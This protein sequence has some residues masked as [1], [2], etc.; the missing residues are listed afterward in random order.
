MKVAEK[1]GGVLWPGLYLTLLLVGTCFSAGCAASGSVTNSGS[2]TQ[3]YTLSGTLTPAA[4]GGGASVGLSGPIAA[5][6][7]AN[8]SGNYSFTNLTNGTY[9][10]TPS[11]PGYT[12]SPT[13]QNVTINGENVTVPTFTATSA[14]TISGTISPATFGSGA[15]VTLSGAG[16]ATSTA[17][18][19]GDFSFTSLNNGTYTI[20]PASSTATFSPTSQNVTVS[21]ANVT[22]VNFIGNSSATQNACG[23]TLTSASPTCQVIGSGHL[24]PAWT[25]ISRHGEY[26]QNET[27]CNIPNAITTPPL[28]ITTSNASYDCG[29]FNE[30]GTVDDTP[31]SW[32]YTTGDIQWTYASFQY[33]T[34]TVRAKMPPLDSGTW[35]AHWFLDIR[36]QNQNIYNASASA[37]ADSDYTEIDMTECKTNSSGY[38]GR[39]CTT[40]VFH[41]TS[42]TGTC[43]WNQTPIDTNFH[44]Y[45]MTWASGSLS[46]TMDGVST[47][48]SFSGAS[49]PSGAVFMII[50]NQ[51]SLGIGPPNNSYLPT[52]M[53]TDFVSVVNSSGTLIF[54]DNFAPDIYFAQTPA[55]TGSG[56]DCADARAT[57]SML[58]MDWV[59]GNTL[60]LCGA[61]TSSITALGSGTSSNPITLTFEPGAY[62]TAPVWSSAINLNGFTFIIV[63]TIPCSGTGCPPS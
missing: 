58:A 11:N 35:P 8:G 10:V 57:S 29:D 49:V 60:H 4:G 12:F 52:T 43:S 42:P 18:S 50:Q 31:T 16:A 47:G 26:A 34:V 3:T 53:V 32:P 59:P 23:D 28:T 55:G 51:T 5:S 20:T 36:C 14:Y 54:Q 7:T 33:G 1:S 56:D 40:N 24:N 61:L 25:V 48:C 62:F 39:W 17:D 44:T 19:S 9:A 37:C 30:N 38:T 6:T 15:I 27:E 21:G 46:V 41:G 13:S 2:S 22:G 63:P 45:V